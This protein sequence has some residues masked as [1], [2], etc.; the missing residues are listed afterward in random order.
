MTLAALRYALAGKQPPSTEK[1]M[2]EGYKSL[3]APLTAPHELVKERSKRLG[4]HSD[5]PA[6]HKRYKDLRDAIGASVHRVNWLT[7]RH[8]KNKTED[9]WEHPWPAP[10]PSSDSSEA[11]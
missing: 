9:I 1:K 10:S 2:L 3:P 7:L 8:G 6:D 5:R 11:H 4:V